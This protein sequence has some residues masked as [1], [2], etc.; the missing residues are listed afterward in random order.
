LILSPFSLRGEKV[1]MRVAQ[2]IKSIDN[3]AKI[4]RRNSTEAEKKLWKYLRSNKIK[5]LKFRRQHPFLNYILDFV[6]LEKK[7]VIEIDG[8]QHAINVEHDR[9]RDLFIRKEG[10]NVLRF[11]NN[12]VLE[13]IEGVIQTIEDKC[14]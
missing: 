11:W 7:L 12:E 1:R 9:E 6:C 8:G 10:F 2:M 13:N 3:L 4:L 5:G 14:L